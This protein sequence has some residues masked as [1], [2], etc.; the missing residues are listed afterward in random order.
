MEALKIRRMETHEATKKG[1][2]DK[3]ASFIASSDDM[4]ISDFQEQ[5]ATHEK[6]PG[7]RVKRKVE[8]SVKR[9]N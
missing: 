9:R 2:L 8:A 4:S 3:N 1:G 7:R 6:E 5:R